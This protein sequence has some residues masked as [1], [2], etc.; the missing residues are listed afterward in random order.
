MNIGMP[1]FRLFYSQD[2][3]QK[4]KDQ[5]MGSFNKNMNLMYTDDLGKT[6]TAVVKRGN[7]FIMTE[8]YFFVAEAISSDAFKIQVS[9][10]ENGFLIFTEA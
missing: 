3:S 6:N 8:N 7:R 9:L 2:L 10:L 5:H 1:K 4:G